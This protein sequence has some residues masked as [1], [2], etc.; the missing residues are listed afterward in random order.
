M[1]CY[2]QGYGEDEMY[3]EDLCR[4]CNYVMNVCVMKL[5]GLKYGPVRDDGEIMRLVQE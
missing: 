1:V 5:I 2:S 4:E 3:F